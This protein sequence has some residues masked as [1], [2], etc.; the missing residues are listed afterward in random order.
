M[1]Y[2][3]SKSDNKLFLGIVYR[4]V[5]T[6][7]SQLLE[8]LIQ[9]VLYVQDMGGRCVITGDFNMQSDIS[10]KII[11]LKQ[12]FTENNIHQLIIDP[13]YTSGSIL[14]HIYT[15]VTSPMLQCGTLPC[16]F[17]DHNAVF[18]VLPTPGD[19][20]DL[21]KL[22]S[23][24]HTVSQTPTLIK[25]EREKKKKV[26]TKQP[27]RVLTRHT[28]EVS[29]DLEITGHDIT[30]QVITGFT[31]PTDE[32]SSL[33][34]NAFGVPVFHDPVVNRELFD[35]RYRGYLRNLRK[36]TCPCII[37]A[38][39][40]DGNCFFRAISKQLLGTEKYHLCL[41]QVICNF[42]ES[43]PNTFVDWHGEGQEGLKRHIGKMRRQRTWGTELELLAV[44]TFFDTSIWEYTEQ[45]PQ[46]SQ[47]WQ[48]IE[49]QKVQLHPQDP[50][51]DG[52]PIHGMFYLH[53]TNGNH[54]DGVFPD[55]NRSAISGNKEVP[56]PSFS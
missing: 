32:D 14:D 28:A 38:T 50:A 11:Q 17:T 24:K 52:L 8:E 1:Y 42:E 21:H 31:L 54:Y 34:A 33:V 36:K 18:C 5:H 20:D 4:P 19:M 13:T 3:I 29:D 22:R 30:S 25:P 46:G 7:F 26:H 23:K 2:E 35:I 45:Y 39:E 49:I 6:K 15:N 47:N 10:D 41:R 53:H 16:Y 12:V 51:V 40:P 55:R 43:H 37:D 56:G 44:A 48:W 9:F 27:I